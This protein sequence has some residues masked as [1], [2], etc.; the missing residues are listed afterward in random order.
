MLKKIKKKKIKKIKSSAGTSNDD[1]TRDNIN[2]HASCGLQITQ[3][4]L[5]MESYHPNRCH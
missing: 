3:K 5:G 1:Y 2:L 4:G